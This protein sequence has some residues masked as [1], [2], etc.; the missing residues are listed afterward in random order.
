MVRTSPPLSLRLVRALLVSLGLFAS[1]PG[2]AQT[3]ADS[4]ATAVR[5]FHEAL[6]RGDSVAAL[7][8][9]APDAM[10]LESG[11]LE[12][13]EEYRSHHL[14][15]DIASARAVPT[16]GASRQVRLAGE[17]A[18]V[19]STSRTAGTFRGRPVDSQ[20]AEL[21][22]LSRDAAGWRI[23]AIHWSSRSRRVGD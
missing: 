23:R 20:N 18:W 1:R 7:A 11:G 21:V 17:V 13:R 14:P 6:A 3:A 19:A 16:T 5:L 22:V 9:L 4:A 15:A 8:L 12:S 2:A 10:I